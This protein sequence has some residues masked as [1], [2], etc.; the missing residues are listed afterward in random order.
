M[1]ICFTIFILEC[2]R[3]LKKQDAGILAG[4]NSIKAR[5]SSELADANDAATTGKGERKRN[6]TISKY[7]LRARL[8]LCKF[9]SSNLIL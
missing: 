6:K 3:M 5:L 7:N 1:D 9:P 4:S 8:L 2:F